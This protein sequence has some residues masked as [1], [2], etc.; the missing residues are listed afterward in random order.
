LDGE[1]FFAFGDNSLMLKYLA[2]PAILCSAII[3]LFVA[4]RIIAKLKALRKLM[5]AKTYKM[6]L[7]LTIALIV[8]VEIHSGNKTCI[9]FHR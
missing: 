7:W 4:Y 5:S 8:Q 6:Q 3:N 2:L 1:M 9:Y